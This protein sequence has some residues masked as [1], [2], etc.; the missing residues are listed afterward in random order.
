MP[1][2]LARPIAGRQPHEIDPEIRKAAGIPQPLS[3][4]RGAWIVEWGGIAGAFVFR[5]GCNVDLRYEGSAWDLL[6]GCRR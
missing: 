2:P 3:D 5:Y 4:A 1:M 6:R